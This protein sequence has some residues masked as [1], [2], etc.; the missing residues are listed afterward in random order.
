MQSYFPV[1]RR[2]VQL[3]DREWRIRRVALSPTYEAADP[4]LLR[5]IQDAHQQECVESETLF[6]VDVGKLGLSDGK[7]TDPSL[8]TTKRH[9]ISSVL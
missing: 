3:I 1:H 2:P 7:S 8:H 9:D 6:R 5:E 4:L